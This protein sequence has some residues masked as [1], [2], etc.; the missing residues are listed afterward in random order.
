MDAPEPRLWTGA[1]ERQIGGLATTRQLGCHERRLSVPTPRRWS[2]WH[3]SRALSESPVF[4]PELPRSANERYGDFSSE[5]MASRLATTWAATA[6][7]TRLR[8]RRDRCAAR[9]WNSA[10]RGA[11]LRVAHLNG[12][13]LAGSDLR[14]RRTGPFLHGPHPPS[15]LSSSIYASYISRSLRGHKITQSTTRQERKIR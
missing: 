12:P 2:L 13:R 6:T 14:G 11:N 8:P 3:S 9:V 5:L 4:R 10:R 1:P 7:Q 15:A